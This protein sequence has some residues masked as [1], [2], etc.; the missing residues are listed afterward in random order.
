MSPLVRQ[1]VSP[2]L[3]APVDVVLVLLFATVGRASH[4]EGLSVG[5]VLETAWPFLVGLAAGWGLVRW[6]SGGWPEHF[7]HGVTVWAATLV[8]G[9]LLRAVTGAGTAWSFVI[10]A[11]LVLAVLLLGSRLLLV[12]RPR[13]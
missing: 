12:W 11:A 4:E 13:T 6:R 10:V 1:H 8:I 5:G 7:G 3:T 2:A 9:M